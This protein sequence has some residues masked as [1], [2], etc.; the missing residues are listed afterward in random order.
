MKVVLLSSTVALATL[1]HA[2]ATATTTRTPLQERQLGALIGGLVA[3]AA[4]MPLHWIYNQTDLLTLGGAAP[5]FH[6]P[7]HCHDD[8]VLTHC[9]YDYPLGENSPYVIR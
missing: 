5:E 6:N 2:T 1:C 8:R 9:D 7:P 3:D 4:V